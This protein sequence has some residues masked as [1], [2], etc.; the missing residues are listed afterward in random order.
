MLRNCKCDLCDKSWPLI[1]KITVASDSLTPKTYKKWYHLL[2]W[3]FS[4]FE[5]ISLFKGITFILFQLTT[6][7]KKFQ[8][9]RYLWSGPQL[10]L[11]GAY[12]PTSVWPIGRTHKYN[13]TFLFFIGQTV[14]HMQGSFLGNFH[15]ICLECILQYQ[16]CDLDRKKWTRQ[17]Y[18]DLSAF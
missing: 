18:S 2:F 14:S 12:F 17:T 6:L 10:S 16:N 3:H 9:I 5:L 15:K 1:T 7:L 11:V 13:R 8:L 4:I